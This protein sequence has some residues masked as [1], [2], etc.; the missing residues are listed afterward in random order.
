MN[1]IPNN[2][3]IADEPSPLENAE[4]IIEP[5][6]QLWVARRPFAVALAQT[7]VTK[8]AQITF[9]LLSSRHRIFRILGTA[10]F[11]ID[12]ATFA[13]FQGV[14]NGFGKIAKHL[15]HFGR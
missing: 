3:Q 2:E 9:A 13:D 14:C 5:L 7:L 1:E 11:E 15:A 10:K 12:M 8:F 4:L 6:D